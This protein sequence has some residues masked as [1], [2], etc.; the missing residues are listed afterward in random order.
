MSNSS[1]RA[2][3]AKT[4]SLPPRPLQSRLLPPQL[5]PQ[6]LTPLPT[7]IHSLPNLLVNRLV[8]STLSPAVVLRSSSQRW[9]RAS[10]MMTTTPPLISVLLECQK[11]RRRRPRSWLLRRPKLRLR[12][13]LPYPPRE[14]LHPSSLWTSFRVMHATQLDKC[15]F[16]PRSK[17]FSS[18]RT[19]PRTVLLTK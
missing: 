11:R 15:V 13:T 4:P 7:Q 3:Q 10:W 12:R 5:V 2:S 8:H 17:P 14:N 18:S 1:H 6:L 19:I 16:P 9:P